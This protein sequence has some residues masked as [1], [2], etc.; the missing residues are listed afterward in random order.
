M[1]VEEVYSKIASH[2]VKGMMI[3]SQM[4]DY[5]R[6]LNLDGYACCHEYHF[7]VE[8][9]SYRKMSNKYIKEHNKLIPDIPIDIPHV[10][11]EAWYKHT[12]QDIDGATVKTGVKN[13]LDTWVKW[14][15][16]TKELYEEMYRELLDN[17]EIC[18]TMIVR[19]LLCD[20]DK[21]LS[22]AEKYQLNKEFIG[23]DINTIVEEQKHKKEKYLNKIKEV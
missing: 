19:E 7:L 6:F 17:G 18:D 21:E 16:E 14:E 12:R 2:M 20:V 3:H 4:A 13:G 11:P 10:I 15:R 23:Y 1:T 5:Y 8:S 22:K 9:K